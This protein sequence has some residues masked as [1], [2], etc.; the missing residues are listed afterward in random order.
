MIVTRLARSASRAMGM[1]GVEHREG[2]P[3]HQADLRV[4]QAKVHLDELRQDCDDLAVEKVEH[5]DDDQHRQHVGAVTRRHERRCRRPGTGLHSFVL[6]SLRETLTVFRAR[7]PDPSP[8]TNPQPPVGK[9][10]LSRCMMRFMTLDDALLCTRL[11]F[12]R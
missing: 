10:L 4:G 8:Q 6:S 2:E 9:N 3:G 12:P 11:T 7:E 5:V 1:P